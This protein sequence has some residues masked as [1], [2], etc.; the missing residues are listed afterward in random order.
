MQDG[1][2]GVGWGGVGWGGVG[3]GGEG[4]GGVGWMKH[5]QYITIA[6]WVIYFPFYLLISTFIDP[7]R[8]MQ[9][10]KAD[11]GPN[12]KFY[13]VFL[14]E[15]IVGIMNV[16]LLIACVNILLEFMLFFFFFFHFQNP[17]SRIVRIC[18]VID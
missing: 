2:G 13:F 6:I 14:R 9:Y 18:Q 12:L 4:W 17:I 8:F 15:N 3:W 5:R 10:I 16:S 11:Y 1:G 7:T